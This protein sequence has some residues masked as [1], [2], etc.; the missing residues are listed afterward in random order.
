MQDAEPL[1]DEQQVPDRI[2][3]RDS[4]LDMGCGYGLV[5]DGGELV[6]SQGTHF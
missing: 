2:E 6:T 1:G 5:L 3:E 4:A